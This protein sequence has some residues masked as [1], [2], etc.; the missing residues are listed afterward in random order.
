[1]VDRDRPVWTGCGQGVD[2]P[3]WTGCGQ[4]VDRVWTGC[5]QT[6]VGQGVDSFSIFSS[7][8]ISIVIEKE[9]PERPAS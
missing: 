7:F 6:G 4:G 3:V 5:G 1:M 8:S 2:R 9:A